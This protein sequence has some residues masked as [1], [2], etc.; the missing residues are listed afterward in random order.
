MR[1]STG[2][3]LLSMMVTAS[4]L[5]TADFSGIGSTT[6][7]AADMRKAQPTYS[8]K[9]RIR[10]RA[11]C[12]QLGCSWCCLTPSGHANCRRM[13]RCGSVQM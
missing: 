9:K 6:A 12:G 11:M 5:I 3:F 13:A 2:K 4:F 1:R 8:S 7:D 10:P